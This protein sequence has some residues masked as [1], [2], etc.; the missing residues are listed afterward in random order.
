MIRSKY[1]KS[2]LTAQ[3]NFMLF[4]WPGSFKKF[5]K[6]GGNVDELKGYRLIPLTRPL[7]FH[8]TLPLMLTLA[9]CAYGEELSFIAHDLSFVISHILSVFGY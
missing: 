4:K 8:F 6:F 9:Y 5:L 2:C 3:I 1:M 7:F